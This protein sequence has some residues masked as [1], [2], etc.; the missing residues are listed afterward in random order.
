MKLKYY[1]AII[2]IS[3][4]ATTDINLYA[5]QI[6]DTTKTYPAASDFIYYQ[7]HEIKQGKLGP[8]TYN[9]DGFVV[10]IYTCP[11]CPKGVFCKQ[12][13]RDNIVISEDK[14]ELELYNLTEKE[15]II[16]VKNPKQFELGKKY[17]FSIK[18]LDYK[19]TGE[20][21]ND[22]DLVGYESVD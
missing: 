15:L 2:C 20:P 18:I 7:I 1:I 17:R 12:C 14:N 3:V 19:S 21:I 8:G 9:T 5:Q 13:M 6:I 22:I 16:F 4:I 11:S 10:K